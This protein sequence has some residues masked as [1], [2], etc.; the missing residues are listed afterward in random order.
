MLL[1]LPMRPGLALGPFYIGMPITK[2]V[3]QVQES[4]SEPYVV[5]VKW[6]PVHMET[7][8]EPGWTDIVLNFPEAGMHLRFEPVSQ[9]LRLIEVY[10]LTRMQVKF[11]QSLV[12]GASNAATFVRVY[13]LFGP[14]FPGELDLENAHYIL[15]YPGLSFTF[16]VPRQHL[17]Q[18]QEAV[19]PLELPDGTTPVASR[20]SVYSGTLGSAAAINTALP[21]Q[22]KAGTTYFEQVSV[23][24]EEGLAFP[25]SDCFARFGASPQ[26]ILSML[27]PPE[28]TYSKAC[29]STGPRPGQ[30]G[31]TQGHSGGDYMYNYFSRGVDILFCGKTHRAKKFVLHTNPPGHSTFNMYAK[32]N[33]CVPIKQDQRP[34]TAAIKKPP[35]APETLAPATVSGAPEEPDVHTVFSVSAKPAAKTAVSESEASAVDTVFAAPDMVEPHVGS[36]GDAAV[37]EQSVSMAAN[38]GD[39]ESPAEDTETSSAAEHAGDRD[40]PVAVLS[41]AEKRRLKKNRKREKENA[42]SDALVEAVSDKEGPSGWV[43]PLTSQGGA[44]DSPTACVHQ[45]A[46]EHPPSSQAADPVDTSGSDNCGA[47]AASDQSALVPAAQPEEVDHEA[48][49]PVQD[50]SPRAAE[51]DK[52]GS[53]RGALRPHEPAEQ[54]AA[55][56]EAVLLAPTELPCMDPHLQ[57]GSITPDSTWDAVQMLLGPCGRATIHTGSSPFGPTYVYGYS[58]I[59]FE[60]MASG[61]LATVTMYNPSG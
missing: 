6:C 35:P 23:V 18:L 33:F 57:K 50:S 28:G 47:E 3:A 56:K 26:D 61:Q 20:I 53:H 40:P 52:R 39:E 60:V 54:S 22:L 7:L 8:Q 27:G 11:S 55:P 24:L 13:D 37:S 31:A 45:A 48:V 36:G 38:P 12:G 19:L 32:C 44:A 1:T 58:G 51:D 21:Q 46:G 17:A 42:S 4:R 5:E 59:V 41:R 9:R 10:D 14:T 25:V 49:P 34:E 30:N 16:P 29:D 15:H 43:D 2:A